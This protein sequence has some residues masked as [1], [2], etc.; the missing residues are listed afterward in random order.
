VLTAADYAL[1]D[2]SIADGHDI[3]SLVAGLTLLPL[4]AATLALLAVGAA[5]VL[6]LVLERPAA[7]RR[8]RRGHI[9]GGRGTDRASADRA[10]THAQARAGMSPQAAAPARTAENAGRERSSRRLAA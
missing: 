5:R 2:W 7:R 3:V 9:A 10:R 8:G 1:W 6:S 4:A